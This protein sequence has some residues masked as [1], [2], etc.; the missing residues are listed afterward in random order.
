MA[1]PRAEQRADGQGAQQGPED[2]GRAD[3]E[4]AGRAAASPLT[5]AAT[6]T[7]LWLSLRRGTLR[8]FTLGAAPDSELPALSIYDFKVRVICLSFPNTRLQLR[9]T[10]ALA[11]REEKHLTRRR[12]FFD[13]YRSYQQDLHVQ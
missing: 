4:L 5:P 12:F 11:K 7:S 6:G 8:V 10:R 9:E 2:A 13:F 3:I 1:E